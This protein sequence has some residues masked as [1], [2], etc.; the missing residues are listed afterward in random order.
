MRLLIQFFIGLY[1]FL[2]RLSGGAIG[3]KMMGMPVLLLNSTGRKTGK[4]RTTPVSYFRDGDSY[5]VTA[6]NGGADRHPGWFYNLRSNPEMTIQVMAENL[7]VVAEQAS[8]EER[9]R[10]WAKLIQLAP[11]FAQYQQKSSREIPMFI[12]RPV[13]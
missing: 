8:P 10:L 7:K 6:S 5:V 3:G 1:T 11:G 13:K 4:Q 12:L 9:S 2:Y